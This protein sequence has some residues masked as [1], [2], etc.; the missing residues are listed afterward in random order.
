MFGTNC[1]IIHCVRFSSFKKLNNIIVKLVAYITS[2][3]HMYS[4]LSFIISSRRQNVIIAKFERRPRL[5]QLY[6]N[7]HN[8]FKM[9]FNF[10][11]DLWQDHFRTNLKV[12][13]NL[14]KLELPASKLNFRSIRGNIKQN[15]FSERFTFISVA[16]SAFWYLHCFYNL[17]LVFQ[18]WTINYI[19][20]KE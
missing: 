13:T 16:V 20:L 2:R 10:E 1:Y 19:L 6:S 8:M 5:T 15:T 14:N 18:C 3:K 11:I 12:N 4:N 9:N 7:C 17:C